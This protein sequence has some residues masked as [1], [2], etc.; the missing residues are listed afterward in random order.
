MKAFKYK[1]TDS[2]KTKKRPVCGQY[3]VTKN[4]MRLA[5]QQK[6]GPVRSQGLLRNLICIPNATRS[7]QRLWA[8]VHTHNLIYIHRILFGDS[9]E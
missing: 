6:P 2:S 9:G 8:A 4:K 5:R 7:N 1:S 3:R